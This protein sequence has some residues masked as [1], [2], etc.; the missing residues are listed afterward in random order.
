MAI[1]LLEVHAAP[2]PTKLARVVKAFRRAHPEVYTAILRSHRSIGDRA[3]AATYGIGKRTAFL[4]TD[5]KGEMLS[6]VQEATITSMED[7]LAKARSTRPAPKAVA[8]KRSSGPKSRVV[9]ERVGSVSQVRRTVVIE[10]LGAEFKPSTKALLSLDCLAWAREGQGIVT[11]SFPTIRAAERA[12]GRM[13]NS[14]GL[15]LM[16]LLPDETAWFSERMNRG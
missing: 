6:R 14:D 9:G 10:G 4:F 15:G 3:L 1:A 11:L 13:L 7:A 16:K 8:R 2:V 12:F 5:E